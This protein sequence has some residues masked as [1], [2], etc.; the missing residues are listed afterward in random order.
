MKFKI[1]QLANPLD[2][3]AA[4]K[5]YARVYTDGVI[6]IKEL[7]E[8]ISQISTVSRVDT[9]AVLE[10]LVMLMPQQLKI[11]KIVRLGE[12]GSFSVS[13][14]SVGHEKEEEVNGNSIKST[15]CLFRPG[16]EIVEA[17]RSIRFK[18]K[19]KVKQ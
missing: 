1:I 8:L 3:S 15:K 12:L 9:R 10:A 5:F 11:G 7:S 18:K 2:R 14:S 16:K 6:D 4:K 17:L 19:E 13:A